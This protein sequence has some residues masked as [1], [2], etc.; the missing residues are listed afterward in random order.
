MMR[1]LIHRKFTSDYFQHTTQSL[2]SYILLNVKHPQNNP[3]IFDRY[4]EVA[5]EPGSWLIVP[6]TP[7]H[8]NEKRA[9]PEGFMDF[10][11]KNPQLNI[12]LDFS[13]EPYTHTLIDGNESTLL[14]RT[15]HRLKNRSGHVVVVNGSIKFSRAPQHIMGMP[16]QLLHHSVFSKEYYGHFYSQDNRIIKN[17]FKYA[18]HDFL[19]LN[20][21]S[22]P[23][24]TALVNRFLDSSQSIIYSLDR[25]ELNN[26]GTE[27][28]W[29]MNRSIPVEKVCDSRIYVCTETFNGTANMFITEKTAKAF[30]MGKPF[31]IMGPVGIHKQLSEWGFDLF[32]DSQHDDTGIAGNYIDWAFFQA[33]KIKEN[34]SAGR[35]LDSCLHNLELFHST[36]FQ[37]RLL[38]E[39]LL[40][41]LSENYT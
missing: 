2:L 19:C 17:V 12:L 9:W 41:P 31:V 11:L 36:Q 30:A 29:Y 1:F 8:I 6:V 39:Y 32:T 22:D 34:Y 21:R 26:W 3:E 10:M 23:S 33:M 18:T 20:G 7:T 38:S 13:G 28:F 25:S 24:R 14:Q 5:M 40:E 37:R 16:A 15:W 4:D 35:Y 27:I